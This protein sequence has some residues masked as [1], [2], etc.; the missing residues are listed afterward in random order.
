M[1]KGRPE[2]QW[3]EKV[4][5]WEASGKSASVWCKE[6]KISIN[7]LCGWKKRLKNLRESS[8]RVQ[9]GFIELK[10]R[11]QSSPGITLEYHGIKIHLSAKFDSTALKQCLDCL[12]GISC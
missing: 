2:P 3:Q 9:S 1:A 11:V 6:N 12:R 7:T 8:G 4:L 10:D 5:D